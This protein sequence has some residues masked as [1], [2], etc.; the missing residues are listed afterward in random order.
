MSAGFF[1]A[2]QSGD[3]AQVKSLLDADASLASAKSESGVSAVLLSIYAGKGEIRDLLLARGVTL[4]LHEAAAAGR[5]DRVKA[6][7][8]A[9]PALAKSCSPDGY[10]VVSLACFFGHLEIARYLAAKGAD[11][12]AAASNGSGY[13]SLTASVTAGHTSVVRWL[14]ESG[15]DPNYRYGPGYSPLL[16]AAANGHLEI[17][18]LL[19]AHG[20]E[21][22]ATAND[23]KSALALAS[24]RNHPDVAEFLRGRA[25]S[26]G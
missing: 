17:A 20:A 10:P 19:L 13:N 11:I 15:A 22:H 5:F 26:A 16:S 6:L 21:L 25:A 9:D 18:K 23:G 7:I 12:N 2:I 1:A 3:L 8:E 24:E 14:L 4:A